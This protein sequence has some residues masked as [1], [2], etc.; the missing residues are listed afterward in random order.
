MREWTRRLPSALVLAYALVFAATLAISLMDL[1]LFEGRQNCCGPANYRELLSDRGYW[2]SVGLTIRLSSAGAL[3]CFALSALL[4]VALKERLLH[5]LILIFILAPWFVPPFSAGM[6]F[7]LLFDGQAGWI[8]ALGREAGLSL[9]DDFLGSSTWT[10]WIA[11]LADVWQ[12][13]G[14]VALAMYI[15]LRTIDPLKHEYLRSLGARRSEII[16]SLTLPALAWPMLIL[17]IVKLLWGLAEFDRVATLTNQ[18]GPFG[19]MR[20]LGLWLQRAYFEFG[21]IGFASAA[22]SLFL[23]LIAF[24]IIAI[25]SL[26]RKF[27]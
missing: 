2:Q 26:R 1:N 14:L 4:V 19:S 10:F 9:T 24:P 21:D 27:T 8:G 13:A 7:Q 12:W 20:V 23:A 16:W 25:Y 18:G 17:F 5:P 15:S 22:A 6:L 11:V 3:A